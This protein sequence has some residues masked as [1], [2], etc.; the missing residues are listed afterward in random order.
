MN[1]AKHVLGGFLSFVLLV[2]ISTGC[3]SAIASSPAEQLKLAPEHLTETRELFE[4]ADQLSNS[5][6]KTSALSVYRDAVRSLEDSPFRIVQTDEYK[7]QWLYCKLSLFSTLLDDLNPDT[8]PEMETLY[9]QLLPL[10]V[11]DSKST[12]SYFQ[13]LKVHFKYL[14]GQFSRAVFGRDKYKACHILRQVLDNDLDAINRQNPDAVA[15]EAS[16]LNTLAYYEA[17]NL[18]GSYPWN[19]VLPKCDRVR[20]IL[21]LAAK[22][23]WTDEMCATY[24]DSIILSSQA[25]HLQSRTTESVSLAQDA[26]AELEQLR[27]EVATLSKCQ[28]LWELQYL[29]LLNCRFQ[30]SVLA[31][32]KLLAILS[33]QRSAEF[34]QLKL[35]ALWSQYEA[36]RFSGREN[37]QKKC[38]ERISK[39]LRAL[40]QVDDLSTVALAVEESFYE[41]SQLSQ[42]ATSAPIAMQLNRLRNLQNKI[43]SVI[44]A[45]SYEEQ[46]SLD[47]LLAQCSFYEHVL[48]PTSSTENQIATLTS[49]LYLENPWDPDV[50]D[51]KI[52]TIAILC[53]CMKAF[54]IYKLGLFPESVYVLE[55]ELATACEISGAAGEEAQRSVKE[56]MIKAGISPDYIR[57]FLAEHGGLV[58]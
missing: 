44:K 47:L 22:S 10:F 54:H 15:I 45:A 43:S 34:E 24:A 20:Q 48:E 29:Y 4:Y 1:N 38:N 19:Q 58:E 16:L 8:L 30:E 40:S 57:R 26:I 12:D 52:Y 50:F 35:D 14:S 3:G 46:L 28:I 33:E 27:P 2:F 56:K 37:D 55:N 9:W 21:N 39:Q 11:K 31:G 25:L 7:S 53:K 6:Q 36:F 13:D 5:D 41:F 42:S 32:D 17:Y 23:E 51:L 18:T 49:K